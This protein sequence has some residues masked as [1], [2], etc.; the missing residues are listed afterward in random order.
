M[1]ATI[2]CDMYDDGKCK[3]AGS[4]ERT[5]EPCYGDQCCLDC[6]QQ[7]CEFICDT[8]AS[9][10]KKRH[11]WA[12]SDDQ[13][14]CMQCVCCGMEIYFFSET[15]DEEIDALCPVALTEGRTEAK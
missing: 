2:K 14:Y 11:D 7:S 1:S 6:E 10:K 4:G 9:I 8:A 15:W 13:G 3:L 5:L 12:V